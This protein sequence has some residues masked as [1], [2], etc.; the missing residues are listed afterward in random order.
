ML[1]AVMTAMVLLED[2]IALALT[3]KCLIMRDPIA[4]GY[5][6]WICLGITLRAKA[7]GPSKGRRKCR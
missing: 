4:I 6:G 1:K 7:S 3:F 2:T 5:Q